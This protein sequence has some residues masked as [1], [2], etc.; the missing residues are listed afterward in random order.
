MEKNVNR[1]F[2]LK[3]NRAME[4]MDDAL[5]RRGLATL[6]LLKRVLE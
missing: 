6:G 5:C 4:S 1:L 2:C 3:L